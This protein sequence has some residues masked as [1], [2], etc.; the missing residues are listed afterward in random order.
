MPSQR[1]GSQVCFVA[2]GGHSLPVNEFCQPHETGL[3][4]CFVLFVC[5]QKGA[6]DSY[7]MSKSHR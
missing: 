1:C 2:E 4:Y 5:F 6:V 7:N 3:L